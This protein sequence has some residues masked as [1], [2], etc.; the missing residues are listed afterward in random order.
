[1]AEN[2][3]ESFNLLIRKRALRRA[4]KIFSIVL[5]SFSLPFSAFAAY[6]ENYSLKLLPNTYIADLNLSNK[7]LAEATR[8]L[9]DLA[10]RFE[11]QKYL[12]KDEEGN[13]LEVTPKELGIKVDVNS[14]LKEAFSR[15]H[16][17]DFYT[18]TKDLIL[19]PFQPK[20]VFLNWQIDSNT[21]EKVLSAKVKDLERTPENARF[22]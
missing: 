10:N 7:R 16:S 18:Q 15:G 4:L 8:L 5:F 22:R 11:N 17:G 19:A 20:R 14:A 6:K 3:E 1:M 12:L 9:Q 2:I 21:F 13:S